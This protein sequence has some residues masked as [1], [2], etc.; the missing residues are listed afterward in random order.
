M[1]KNI[2]EILI[3]T[4]S[5][6]FFLTGILF[7]E[8]NIHFYL[9]SYFLVATKIIKKA[10]K[11]ILKGNFFEE[12]SF[13]TIATLSAIFINEIPEGVLVM[14]L[15]RIGE[16]LQ[17]LSIE[18]SKNRIKKILELKPSFANLKIKG[19]IKKV[20]P[21]E[22]KRGDIIF[23]KPGERV[24]LDGIII[25][26]K[27]LID[28]SPITG[29]SVPRLFKKG[30]NIPAGVINKDGVL[31]IRVL[32]E[33]KESSITKILELALKAR[34]RKA[35][36]EK[37]ITRFAKYYT[38]SVLLISLFIAF[39]I[40]LIT[41][42]SFKDSIYRALV[43]L[44]ISCPCALVISIPL[45]YFTGI[46]SLAKKGI[47]IKGSNYL[48]LLNGIDVFIFDK[49][50]TITKGVF[51]VRDVF[52]F[53]GFS[54]EELI[55]IAVLAEK[56]SN[57]PIA[58]AIKDFYINYFGKEPENIEP[59]EFKEKPGSGVFAKIRGKKIM[60]G[61]DRLLHEKDIVHKLCKGDGTTVHVVVNNIYAGYLVISDEIKKEAEEV[62][63]KLK[64]L[65]I[66]KVG[67]LTGDERFPAEN[68]Y[69]K[70]NLDF[71]KAELLPEEKVK[72]IEKLRKKNK[73]AFI[74]DGINDAAAIAASD[75][76]IAMGAMGQDAA[77]ESADLV[78]MDDNLLKILSAIKIAKK[79]KKIV[80]QNIIFAI[81]VKLL[82]LIFGSLGIAEMWEAVFGDMGVSLIAIFNAMRILKV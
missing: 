9:F 75:V 63:K 21:E 34:E 7:E 81:G 52:T 24:P 19:E 54:K 46:G 32:K 55:E 14:L 40:P 45:S 26:G 60:V 49:T 15:F 80:W 65:G 16:F 28:T 4:L 27:S 68:I 51:K 33:E 79:T 38:P 31:E 56:H 10:I 11:N 8:K 72:E 35:N 70:L 78:I 1:N 73:V 50:G 25:K 6:A 74:G 64:E 61:S 82:F 41:P 59:E 20:K 53:N 58:K 69:K 22:V 3:I 36:T 13:M 47:L 76:G 2:K 44:V 57:H 39:I 17:E 77:I 42:L 37:F 66:K 5:I 67:M 48:D 29:E 12:N 62:I 23:V 30:D 71:Y 43:L 18:K